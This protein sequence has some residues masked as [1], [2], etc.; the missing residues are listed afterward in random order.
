M[1]QEQFIYWLQGF[2]ELSQ[3]EMP[4]PDQ[5]MMICDHLKTVFIKVTPSYNPPIYPSCPPRET[6]AGPP[7]KSTIATATC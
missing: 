3:G 2:V 6:S 5:W 4:T 7:Y 1:T